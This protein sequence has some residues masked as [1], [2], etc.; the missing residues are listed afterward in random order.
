MRPHQLSGEPLAPAGAAWWPGTLC[1]ACRPPCLFPTVPSSLPSAQLSPSP[2]QTKTTAAQAAQGGPPA[3]PLRAWPCSGAHPAPLEQT[4]VFAGRLGG[5]HGPVQAAPLWVLKCG[6][7]PPGARGAFRDCLGSNPRGPDGRT[8]TPRLCCA[9]R[10]PCR[11]RRSTTCRG[12]YV[13][14]GARPVTRA[15]GLG[16]P[17]SRWRAP[18]TAHQHPRGRAAS[19][20]R[21]DPTS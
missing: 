17:G 21:G 6:A 10:P 3:L 11:M 9:R 20:R 16:S 1:H 13:C 7:A 19:P 8:A 14:G 4:H 12:L 18:L 2:R 5:R 15:V